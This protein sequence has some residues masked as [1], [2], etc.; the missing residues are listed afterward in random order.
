MPHGSL[1][2]IMLSLLLL[3][4]YQLCG[5]E[6]LF[7]VGLKAFEGPVRYYP[8]DHLLSVLTRLYRDAGF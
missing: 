6:V 7:T 2:R 5:V 4:D 1:S 8:S 3:Q